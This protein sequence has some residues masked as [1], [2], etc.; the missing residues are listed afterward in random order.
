M[1]SN[2]GGRRPGQHAGETVR[3]HARRALAWL[4]VIV[5]VGVLVDLSFG[6]KSP[7][8]I[9][10]ELA[11]I[12]GMLG[13]HRHYAPVVGRWERGADGERHVGGILDGLADRGWRVLH[14][15][16]TGRGNIDHIVVGPGG[17]FSVETKSHRGKVTADRVDGR[18]LAQAY[19]QAKH[20]E[21]LVGHAVSPL[22]VFSQAYLIGR[23]IS[24][25]R[26]VVVLPA[27]MLVGFLE[28]RPARLP[29]PRVDDLYQ[30]LLEALTVAR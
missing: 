4:L 15:V 12:A 1:I 23:P 28:R 6:L 18:M 8:S 17:V 26:G 2:A 3:R 16:D 9:A 10:I 11:A 27:R 13:L 5:A 30:Q 20:V 24:R 29:S 7:V 25:R 19:A 22:L 14:D 21:S